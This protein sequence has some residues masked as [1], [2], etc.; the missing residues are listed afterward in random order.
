MFIVQSS[1]SSRAV[2]GGGGTGSPTQNQN[3]RGAPRG[4]GSDL[5]GQGS[6][7]YRR[8]GGDRGGRGGGRFDY[9]RD[10]RDSS[11]WRFG[12]H[13]QD[14]GHRGGVNDPRGG[15]EHTRGSG[16]D[17]G[18]NGSQKIIPPRFQRSRGGGNEIFSIAY[19]LQR[20]LLEESGNKEMASCYSPGKSEFKD[21]SP[22]IEYLELCH[23]DWRPSDERNANWLR[24]L[25]QLR[26]KIVMERNFH[27]IEI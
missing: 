1:F 15:V 23:P 3:N 7:Q 9:H 22:G 5:R 24:Y 18:G 17:R 4:G 19:T 20:L 12:E 10:S 14:H 11:D 16:G 13:Q 2:S 8:G 6:Q 26:K 27:K 21:N 25:S